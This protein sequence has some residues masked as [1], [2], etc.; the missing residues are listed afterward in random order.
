MDLK[1]VYI[2]NYR[3]FRDVELQFNNNPNKNF[4]IIKGNNGAGSI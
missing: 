2:K 3:Q 1:K 4:T